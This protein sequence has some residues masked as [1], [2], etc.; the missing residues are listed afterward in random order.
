MY[1]LPIFRVKMADFELY[2][3]KVYRTEDF[4][5]LVA[6]GLTAGE[7]PEYTVQARL[8]EAG[9]YV[10]KA[11]DIRDGRRSRNVPLLLNV[12]C[13][14]GYRPAGKYVIDTHPQPRAIDVYTLLIKTRLDPDDPDCVAFKSARLGDKLFTSQA[15]TLDK[16]VREAVQAEK[17]LLKRRT[18]A[19]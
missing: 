12:L 2:L 16:M 3:R 13:I 11:A 9:E 10:R 19:L 1:Q 8:P 14:D 7:C 18:P 15:A 5:F 6:A 17:D 4:D